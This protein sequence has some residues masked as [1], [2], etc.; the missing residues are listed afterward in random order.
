MVERGLFEVPRLDLVE[1]IRNVGAQAELVETLRDLAA[2]A[3]RN[4]GNDAVGGQMEALTV[5]MERA[6]KA[7]EALS[8]RLNAAEA[9]RAAAPVATARPVGGA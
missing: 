6:R 7:T 8:V 9:P 3:N 2:W 1:F 4:G 5:A